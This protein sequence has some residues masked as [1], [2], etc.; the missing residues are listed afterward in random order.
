[1]LFWKVS[2][3]TLVKLP[4]NSMFTLRFITLVGFTAKLVTS[5]CADRI[6]KI[7]EAKLAKSK[8]PTGTSKI[9]FFVNCA[10]SIEVLAP[11]Y[12]IITDIIMAFKLII[13]LA[14]LSAIALSSMRFWYMLRNMVSIPRLGWAMVSLCFTTISRCFLEVS[15]S[16]S[17]MI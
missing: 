4:K 3:D 13:M 8:M 17:R 14:L 12:V 15:R 6:A 2:K 16:F 11:R 10:P 7:T 9:G 5:G 1:M